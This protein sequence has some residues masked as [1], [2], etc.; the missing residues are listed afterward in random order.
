MKSRL[1]WFASFTERSITLLAKGPLVVWTKDVE[2]LFSDEV[3]K[4]FSCDYVSGPF[5]CMPQ[6]GRTEVST[7]SQALAFAR[8]LRDLAEQVE[9]WA[10]RLP[11]TRGML[12]VERRV[13]DAA[14]GTCSNPWHDAPL[15]LRRDQ[16]S[17]PGAP[18]TCSSC[19]AE[20]IE[21]GKE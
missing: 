4:E 15:E 9:R 2:P 16:L 7:R 3:R 21:K 5:G 18:D 14:M 10:K 19:G 1:R 13:A 20:W 17:R 12:A 6:E 8:G 11:T